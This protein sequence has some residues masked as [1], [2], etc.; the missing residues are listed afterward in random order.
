MEQSQTLLSF[1]DSALPDLAT[2][3]TTNSQ[4]GGSHKCKALDPCLD[5]LLPW[6]WLQRPPAV[7]APGGIPAMQAPTRPH[8]YSARAATAH[9]PQCTPPATARPGP[10]RSAA[11]AAAHARP[12]APHTSDCLSRLFLIAPLALPTQLV[13]GDGRSVRAP[14]RPLRPCLAADARGHRERYQRKRSHQAL[15]VHAVRLRPSLVAHVGSVFACKLL[16]PSFFC[17]LGLCKWWY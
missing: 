3:I 15:G 5:A 8:P 17:L 6:T 9:T 10:A 16:V 14:W 1:S 11:P 2:D 7:A 4:E 12:L 13:I